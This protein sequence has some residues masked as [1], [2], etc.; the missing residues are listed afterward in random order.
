VDV[1]A[2]S[3]AAVWAVAV[4]SRPVAALVGRLREGGA[5]VIAL[6]LVFSEPD[7]R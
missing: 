7:G 6:D 3:L 5:R 1:D 4:A 2:A